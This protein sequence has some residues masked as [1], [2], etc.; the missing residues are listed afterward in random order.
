MQFCEP[1]GFPKNDFGAS[2]F[3]PHHVLDGGLG[4]QGLIEREL[5]FLRVQVFPHF[6]TGPVNTGDLRKYSLLFPLKILSFQSPLRSRQKLPR[7]KENLVAK[8]PKLSI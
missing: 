1:L 2:F 4:R 7:P 8:A 6:Q 3:Y 5:E